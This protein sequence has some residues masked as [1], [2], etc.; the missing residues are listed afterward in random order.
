MPV[1]VRFP[2]LERVLIKRSEN[3]AIAV[4]LPTLSLPKR[5]SAAG[6][7]DEGHHLR[8]SSF[9]RK[10]EM[11][12]VLSLEPPADADPMKV[13]SPPDSMYQAAWLWHCTESWK[14]TLLRIALEPMRSAIKATWM[15]ATL[16]EVR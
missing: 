14:G 11:E 6:P 3:K 12:E 8:G 10:A 15:T 2:A 5:T 13:M 4:M 16:R 1:Q 7:Q 9:P